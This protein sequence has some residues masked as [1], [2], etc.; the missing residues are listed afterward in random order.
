[1]IKKIRG[2]AS[3]TELS[4]VDRIELARAYQDITGKRSLLDTLCCRYFCFLS[5][6]GFGT[7]LASTPMMT[8]FKKTF[9]KLLRGRDLIDQTDMCLS[10][11]ETVS[12][13]TRWRHMQHM[14]ILSD[15]LRL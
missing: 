1:M 15:S 8:L 13:L 14:W 5:I 10:Q 6:I 4:L 11:M 12:K 9:L 3:K 7:F 2:P